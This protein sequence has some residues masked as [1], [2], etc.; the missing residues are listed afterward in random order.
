MFCSAINFK[1]KWAKPFIEK[2]TR[3]L[4]FILPTNEKIEVPIMVSGESVQNVY[5]FEKDIITEIP[6]TNEK[7]MRIILPSRP[8]DLH[9][10]LNNYLSIGNIEDQWQKFDIQFLLPK[11]EF[12]KTINFIP[13]L[14]KIGITR[15]F[16]K[17]NYDLPI[18]PQDNFSIDQIEQ[19]STI[20]NQEYGTEVATVTIVSTIGH[21]PFFIVCNRPFI[22]LIIDKKTNLIILSGTVT[23]PLQ[24]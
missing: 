13:I 1:E 6:Y 3:P 23:N 17:S 11:F 20:K 7:V 16:E 2:L 21:S 22:Y 18:I 12:L 15:L 10:A 9:Q 24:S 8:V 19:I 4:E 5:F 14:K